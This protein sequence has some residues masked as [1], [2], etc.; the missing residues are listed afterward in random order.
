MRPLVAALLLLALLPA[1]ASAH[2]V[3]RETVP[4]R[5]SA[6]KAA[7]EIVELRFSEPVEAEFGAVRVYDAQGRQVQVGDAYHPG[8]KGP[9]VAVKLKKGLP[10]GGYTAT[11]RVISAD[12]HPVSSGFV[13]SV[14]E[15]G[16]AGTASVEDLLS[17]TNAGPVT[18]TAL[19]AA[20]ALQYA[21][22]AA[23]L[24]G[25]I[26]LLLA[27]V[28][29]LREA[30]G[31]SGGWGA[32]ASAFARRLR[33]LLV[34]AAVTGAVSA[35]AGIVLQGATASGTSAWAALDANVVG[36]VLGTRF[37]LT[38]GLSVLFW[39]V[40]GVAALASARALP[41]LR[42]AS[43][44]ATGLAMPSP[45]RGSLILLGAPLLALAAMPALGGHASV[46]SPR[47]LLL[48]LNIVHVAAMAAWLGGIAVL[49]L[50]LRAATAALEPADRVRLLA[51]TVSRF[52]AIATV[53]IAA[54][55][56]TGVL[57]SIVYI[58]S[59]GQLL[60][61]PFGRSVLIKS[62]LFLAICALGFV[63]RNRL[64]PRL[65]SAAASGENPGRT[66]VL[67]RRALRVELVIGVLVIAVTGALA[68]YAPSS[69]ESAGPFS[70]SSVIGDARMEVTVDPASVGANEMHVYLFD[71]KSGAQYE[72]VEE[73]TL[74]ASLPE[75]KIDDLDLQATKSGPGHYTINGASFGVAGDWTIEVGARIGEFDLNTAKFELPIE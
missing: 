35:A 75:K 52:S 15:G 41:V 24:G 38:W 33:T 72:G 70:T 14:G 36:D 63:N 37:G 46:Q 31:G 11:F 45:G 5:G 30:A 66:G 47:A 54:I 62:L 13:F 29:A 56:L 39:L 50:A 48:S 73:L 1:G 6:L 8:D 60:D 65:R 64:L 18:T 40:A 34:A 26:F 12:S 59:F 7:P 57:Q 32:A 21:A 68:S 28:P 51:A 67:L 53:A 9:V 55:V 19:G 20:R 16:A 25:F 71:R 44:G 17:G 3:L 74:S 61:T 69:A 49:V 23:G 27:W 42:P 58:E 22:I 2:A 43:V 4:A 10:E